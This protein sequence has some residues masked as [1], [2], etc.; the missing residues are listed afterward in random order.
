MRLLLPIAAVL[1]LLALS[2]CEER[3]EVFHANPDAAQPDEA[4][5]K[6]KA[7]MAALKAGRLQHEDPAESKRYDEAVR[8]LTRRGSKIEPQ[9]IE[10]L[11]GDRDWAVRVGC[12]EVLQS[13]GSKSSIEHLIAV[14]D[15]R[16]PI[17]AWW[18]WRTL[19][20]LVG[21]DFIPEA[22]LPPKDG[23]PPVPP[24]DGRDLDAEFRS[25]KSWHSAHAAAHKAAWESWWQD[26]R[27][28]ITLK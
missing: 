14:L 9:L 15:D 22:G 16:E 5:A 21:Q 12:I 2:G 7:D 25:W 6:I 18:S 3:E 20:V 24:A 28:T 10:A 26:N 13:V 8:A 23:L 11:R 27:K 17:V 4:V 19:K 1:A